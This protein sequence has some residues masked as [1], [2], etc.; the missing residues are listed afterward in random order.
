VSG[1]LQTLELMNEEAFDI[2]FETS[3]ITILPKRRARTSSTRIPLGKLVGTPSSRA[4][5][6]A[7]LREPALQDNASCGCVDGPDD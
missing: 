7:D 5:G 2:L 3:L 1:A 6:P 4:P